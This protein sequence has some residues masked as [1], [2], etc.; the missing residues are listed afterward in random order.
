MRVAP[1]LALFA[2]ACAPTLATNQTFLASE[3]LK[4]APTGHAAL[5]TTGE[6]FD[7]S[8]IKAQEKSADRVSVLKVHGAYFVLGEGFQ[9]AWR[10]W[11]AGRDEVHY[12]P[13]DLSPGPQGFA[14]ASLETSGNCALLKW[15]GKQA[16]ITSDGD[17]NADKCGD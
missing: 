8:P 4:L 5:K 15:S 3:E 13:L 14:G 16:F 7:L 6:D 1:L 11:P 10:L 17:V 2:A 9:H 12:K